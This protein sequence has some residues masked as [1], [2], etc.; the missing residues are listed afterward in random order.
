[1]EIS[2]L[3]GDVYKNCCTCRFMCVVE[4]MRTGMCGVKTKKVMMEGG[5]KRDVVRSKHT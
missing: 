2:G 3:G 1:M 5:E 4:S